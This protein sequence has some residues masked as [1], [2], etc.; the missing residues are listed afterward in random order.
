MPFQIVYFTAL[1]PY[2]LL[3]VLFVRGVTLEGAGDGITFYLR[4]N[5]TRLL[6]AQVWMDGATQILY[7]VCVGQGLV[8]SFGSYNKFNHKCIR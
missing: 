6:D 1:F 4:P 5:F 8:V 2:V 3:T 7:S